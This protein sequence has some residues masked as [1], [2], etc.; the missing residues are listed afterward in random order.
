[1]LPLTMKF[2]RILADFAQKLIKLCSVCVTSLT[3]S[4]IFVGL[5]TYTLDTRGNT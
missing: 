4:S 2:G 3:A 1:M 5:G